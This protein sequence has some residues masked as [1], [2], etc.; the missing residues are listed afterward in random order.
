MIECPLCDWKVSRVIDPP[1]GSAAVAGALG[2]SIDVFSAAMIDQQMMIVEQQLRDH[3]GEHKLE[4]WV[5]KVV[6]QQTE[7]R[8]LSEVLTLSGSTLAEPMRRMVDV[9]RRAE[10]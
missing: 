8:R 6:D 4:E 5:A 1:A 2:L 9:P 3:F 10:S 7:I